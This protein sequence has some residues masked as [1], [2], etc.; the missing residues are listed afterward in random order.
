M[1]SSL[2]HDQHR[3]GLSIGLHFLPGLI[4]FLVYIFI[5][6]VVMAW[7]FPPTFALAMTFLFI[8]IPLELGILFYQGK[9]QNGAFSLEGVVLYRNAKPYWL[10][11]LIVPLLAYAALMSVLI[12]PVSTFLTG[13]VF[14]ALPDWFLDPSGERAQDLS[15]GALVVFLAS[16]LIIDGIANPVVEELYFRGYLLPRISR[17]K[18]WAP[19]LHAGLF[20][21]AHLWQPQNVP[22]IFLLVAPLYYLVWWKQNIYLSIAAHSLANVI[23]AVLII[24]TYLG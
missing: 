15:R 5:A 12:E 18:G 13:T 14:S 6:R 10:Y 22:L 4:I 9:K 21:M 24:G 3:I 23:G 11:F 1:T 20:A 7:G 17:F 16:N 2:D 19:L 8:G